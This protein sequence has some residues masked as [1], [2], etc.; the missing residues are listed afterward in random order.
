M[1]ISCRFTAVVLSA[2]LS[3]N[4]IGMPLTFAGERPVFVQVDQNYDPFADDEQEEK[5]TDES[6]LTF[7]EKL[8]LK[9]KTESKETQKVTINNVLPG[10]IYIP[11]GTVLNVELIEDAN[12]KSHKKNQQVEFRMIEHLIINGVIVIPKGTIGKGYVYESQK[13][14][15]FGRK[16]VL[17]IAA[18]EI[19][20]VNNVTVPLKKGLEGKGRTDGGAVAVAAAVSLIGGIFMKGSNVNYPAGTDFKVEVRENTDLGVKADELEK[21]MDPNI[22]HGN[23]I[24]ID[25][26]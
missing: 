20:T 16:G 3:V 1:K 4:I 17:R 11:K 14:G 2:I 19:K 18:Q 24:I 10:H 9:K 22:P 8:A 12:P 23:E 25:V 7:K 26:R 15:G 21:A 13:P 6:K 5:P